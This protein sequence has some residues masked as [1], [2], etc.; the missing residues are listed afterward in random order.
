R[1]WAA[2]AARGFRFLQSGLQG[3]GSGRRSL[4]GDSAFYKAGYEEA[5]VG[6]GRCP[7]AFILAEPN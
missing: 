7:K 6:G 5:E 2:V 4:P 3:S 1:K